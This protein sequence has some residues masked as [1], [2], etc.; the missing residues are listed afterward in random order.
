MTL[1]PFPP[2]LSEGPRDALATTREVVGSVDGASADGQVTLR[3]PE[4]GL[5]GF[6]AAGVDKENRFSP[7]YSADND[8]PG[9]DDVGRA[10]V[11]DRVRRAR[12]PGQRT[13]RRSVRVLLIRHAQSQTNASKDTLHNGRHLHVP[14]SPQGVDQAVALGRR[15]GDLGTTLHR[16]VASEAVRAQQTAEHMLAAMRATPG[17]HRQP[18]IEVAGGICEICMGGWTGKNI[19]VTLTPL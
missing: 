4:D 11:I 7:F 6:L 18:D 12:E 15:L 9:S 5:Q 2:P 17:R 3:M 1:L 8:G 10:F 19:Q 14:L 13:S 16:V